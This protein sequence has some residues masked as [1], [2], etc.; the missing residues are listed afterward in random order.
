MRME[1]MAALALAGALAAAGV[2]GETRVL[3]GMEFACVPVGEFLMGSTSSEASDNEQPV[4]WVRISEGYWLGK[5]EV[6]QQEWEAVM[7]ENPAGSSRCRR[8]PVENVSWDDVQEFIEKLN[9]RAGGAVYRLPTEAEWEYSARAET[10]TARILTR[11]RGTTKT[12]ESARIRRGR[13]QRTS[14]P[15]MTCW[16]TCLSGCRTGKRTIF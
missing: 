2:S 9:G 5:Y 12:A 15:C 4:A 10:A 8:C 7:G 14:G 16:G 6:T 11:S 1:R 3:D 13:R